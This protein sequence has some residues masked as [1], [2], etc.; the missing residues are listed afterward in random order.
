LRLEKCKNIGEG[1]WSVDKG[2]AH[3]LVKVLRVSAR[4]EVEGLLE[5]EKLRLRLEGTE[6]GLRARR[7]SSVP[8]GKG[9]PRI[10]LLASLL[11]GGDFELLLR[12][13]TEVGVST[14]LP[15][16]ANRSVLRLQ[17]EEKARRVARWRRIL[18]EATL[19]CGAASIPDLEFPVPLEKALARDLPPLK[20]AGILEEATVP[21]AKVPCAPEAV[22]AI[23]PE[24]DWD[25]KEIMALKESGF[26]AVSLGQNVLKAF[27]AA[28]VACSYLVLAWEGQACGNVSGQKV[29]D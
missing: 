10:T 20:V 3:H 5:G 24:G 16:E 2:Q 4:E 13:V 27:T 12:G 8:A 11:K 28:V 6:E 9:L 1:L 14:I 18:E 29:P 15:V 26:T 19:Q 22:V 23:G 7:I 25:E 21:L 17:G